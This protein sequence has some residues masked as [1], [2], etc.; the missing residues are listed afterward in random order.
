VQRTSHFAKSRQQPAASSSSPAARG[1]PQMHP[2]PSECGGGEGGRACGF[3][4]LRAAGRPPGGGRG[5]QQAAWAG[6]WAWA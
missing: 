6:A 1:C 4:L 3:C 2:R 5:R